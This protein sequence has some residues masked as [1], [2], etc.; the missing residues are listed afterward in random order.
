MNR[1]VYKAPV[2]ALP[3]DEV[4][5]HPAGFPMGDGIVAEDNFVVAHGTQVASLINGRGFGVNGERVRIVDVKVLN[6]KGIGRID[7]VLRGLNYVA[8]KMK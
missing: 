5:E 3:C 4:S 8:G 1:T 2:F 6:H 7:S